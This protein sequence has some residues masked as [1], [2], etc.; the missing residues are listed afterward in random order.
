MD[1]NDVANCICCNRVSRSFCAQIALT[2]YLI[3]VL[4]Y[5]IYD[6]AGLIRESICNYCRDLTSGR[7]DNYRIFIVL[8]T[9]RIVN[10]NVLL[11]IALKLTPD[12]ILDLGNNNLIATIQLIDQIARLCR[13]ITNRQVGTVYYIDAIYASNKLRCFRFRIWLYR[14]SNRILFLRR[15]STNS[16]FSKDRETAL[17][18]I[19][20]G[21]PSLTV[22]FGYIVNLE[23][24][25]LRNSHLNIVRLDAYVCRKLLKSIIRIA[26]YRVVVIHVVTN[27]FQIY[28][29]YVIYSTVFSRSICYFTAD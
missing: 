20:Y 17:V 4:F 6:I 7:N 14:R 2:Y 26:D 22:P 28:T 21:H 29:E 15:I 11:R 5:H 16:L 1:R 27:L 10:I 19:L 23:L 25:A 9:N 24:C 12:L 18:V 13:S 3:A 8:K